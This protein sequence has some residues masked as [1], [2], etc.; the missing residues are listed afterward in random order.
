M[1]NEM[2][3]LSR[4]WAQERKK[5]ALIPTMGA[6]HQG[7]LTLVT[8]AKKEYDKIVVSI[9]VN[10][11]QFGPSEDFSKYPR[12]ENAD[13][14]LLLDIGVDALFTPA[15]DEVY[16]GHSQTV[17]SVP[18]IA[19]ILCGTSRPGHFEG[20]CTV[21]TKLFNITCPDGA[22]FGKKDFQQFTIL[23]HLVKDLNFNINMHGVETVRET[24]GLAMSS[25]NR[26]LSS[27]EREEAAEIY[28]AMLAVREEFLRGEGNVKLL[29]DT[30][31]QKLSNPIFKIEY[32]EIRDSENL[33]A[34]TAVG[35]TSALILVA[36]NI[37]RTR[38]IDNL[39]LS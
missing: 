21:V 33:Q 13:T 26:Y 20:V 9:F 36:V 1:K 24:D 5:I 27:A 11:M 23:K 15:V 16:G 38:L 10:P 17:V 37:G 8:E 31:V 14:Q 34:L 35:N 29:R 4:T 18:K 22:F 32:C 30:F 39:L 28:R 6:L 2:F 19:E 12:T 3:H 25:R 7:H